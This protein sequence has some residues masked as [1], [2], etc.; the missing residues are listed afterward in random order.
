MK[1]DGRLAGR[2]KAAGHYEIRL[3]D[4]RRATTEALEAGQMK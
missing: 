3:A 1:H 2:A 4:G